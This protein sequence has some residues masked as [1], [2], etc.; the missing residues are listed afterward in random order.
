MKNSK[1]STIG[2][3]KKSG[4]IEYDLTRRLMLASL[5]NALN[6]VE[7]LSRFLVHILIV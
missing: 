6:V 5:F 3:C 7:A 1:S 2:D 4:L